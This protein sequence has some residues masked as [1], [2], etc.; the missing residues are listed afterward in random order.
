MTE[1]QGLVGAVLSNK[2]RLVRLLGEGGMGAV[3]ATDATEAGVAIAV[4]LLRPEFV[5]EEIVRS[6]FL[7]EAKTAER[8]HHPNIARVFRSALAEDGTPYLVMELL[9]G[10][11]LSAYTKDGGRVPLH[12]AKTIMFGILQ[13]LAAAHQEGVVHRDLKPDNV[14]LARDPA[15]QFLVKLLDFGIAK[16]MDVAGGM[17]KKTRTGMLLGTPAYM[18]PEQILNA[19]DADPRADLFSAAVMFYEML[20]GRVAFPAPTE[21]ARLGVVLNTEPVPIDQVDAQLAPLSAFMRRGF[22][23]KREQRFQSAD[24]MSRALA[25]ALEAPEQAMQRTSALSQLPDVNALYVPSSHSPPPVTGLSETQRPA[26]TGPSGTLASAPPARQVSS[27]PPVVSPRP[28]GEGT[29]PSKD[30]PRGSR[31]S[32]LLRTV[33]VWLVLLL[34][35]IAWMTGVA[36][37]FAAGRL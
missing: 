33:P 2:Y 20:T 14:F 26:D 6:R 18:A 28:L 30:R 8:L 23:K 10:L 7:E 25:H 3:Y 36:T 11:P 29:L 24:E 5:T 1:A 4:K 27:R 37:G 17:G 12:H 22:A 15:G 16:V 35:T 32:V 21:F 34:I 31:G 19:K 13:G 9:E